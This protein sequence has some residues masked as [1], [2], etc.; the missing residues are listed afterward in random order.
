MFHESKSSVDKWYN[1]DQIFVR[2]APWSGPYKCVFS[3][4][5]RRD[6]KLGQCLCIYIHIIIIYII[7]LY[8]ITLYIITS[9]SRF[10]GV[11][12]ASLHFI[13]VLY[14]KEQHF[15][16]CHSKKWYHVKNREFRDHKLLRVEK[17]A[18]AHGHN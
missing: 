13:A 1:V 5:Y 8:H 7:T 14:S 11:T 9:P 3:S 16:S 6:L 4:T 10:G 17:F 2:S 18:S 15:I 12:G